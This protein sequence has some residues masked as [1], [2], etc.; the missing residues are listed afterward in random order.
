M[1]LLE[2]VRT[3]DRKRLYDYIGCLDKETLKA[4]DR[5]LRVSLGMK[6]SQREELAVDTK[7]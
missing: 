4:V 6:N 2:Q 3:L 7:K 5:G 1:I